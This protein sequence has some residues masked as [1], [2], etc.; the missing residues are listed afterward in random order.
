MFGRWPDA[1]AIPEARFMRLIDQ[2]TPAQSIHFDE[3]GTW[4]V[5]MIRVIIV[6]SLAQDVQGQNYLILGEA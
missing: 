5:Y 1:I 4:W 3:T 2:Q 6:R